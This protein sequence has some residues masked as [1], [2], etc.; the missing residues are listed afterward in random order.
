MPTLSSLSHLSTDRQFTLKELMWATTA[1]ACL[2]AYAGR[3]GGNSINLGIAYA[4][5]ATGSGIAFGVAS[6]NLKDALFWSFLTTLLVYMAVAGGRLPSA[7]VGYGWGIVG[8]LPGAINGIRFPKSLWLGSVLSAF[9]GLCGFTWCMR[10][11][12]QPL[13]SSVAFDLACALV[14]AALLRP[15]IQFLQWF[16]TQSRQPRIVLAAWLTLSIVIGNL[17]VPIVAGVQR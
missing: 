4:S 10:W 1:V 14:V 16:E 7:A 17:L 3:L 12:G 5:F 8:A 2:L 15:F 6:R 11:L 13:D 9:L